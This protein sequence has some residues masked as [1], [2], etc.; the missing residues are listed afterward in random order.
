MAMNWTDEEITAVNSTLIPKGREGQRPV[1]L[2][3]SPHGSTP[4]GAADYQGFPLTRAS[5]V[6]ISNADFSKS[7]SPAN[8]YGV[9]QSIM[10]TWVRCD[11][12]V[13]DRARVFH[14]IDGRFYN[15]SFRRIG[16]DRCGFVG[17][18][19][20]CDFSGTS[21]RNAHLVANFIRCKFHDCNMKVASWGSSFEDCE[22]AGAN[23]DKLFQDVRDVALSEN[24]VTFVVLTGKVHVGETR[25]IA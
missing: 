22:F 4:D 11:D 25:H 13:F 7:R 8:E 19:T 1:E 5:G 21:F 14:R 6:I 12:V 18:F 24:A 20:D 2:Q 15:C 10:L 16:T 23:I 9:D 3:P 17:T